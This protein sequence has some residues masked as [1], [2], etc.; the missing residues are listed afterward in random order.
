MSDFERECQEQ[1]DRIAQHLLDLYNGND[2]ELD[3]LNEQM[4]ALEDE[5]PIEP[6]QEEDETDEDYDKRYEEYEKEHE[7]WDEK[8]SELQDKIDACEEEDHSIRDYLEDF[9]D[10]DYIVNSSKEYQSC[11][12]W[13]TV[14]GPGICIDTEDAEVKLYWGGTHTTAPISYNVRDEI[15]DMFREYYDMM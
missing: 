12:V 1:V 5:E 4:E 14:G 11:R 7:A 15:D 9:L 10:V 3:E 6:D 2:D 13:V 8:V